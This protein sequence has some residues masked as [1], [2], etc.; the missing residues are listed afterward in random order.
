[1]AVPLDTKTLL[2][3]NKEFQARIDSRR[4]EIST[5]FH[6]HLARSAG[7][8]DQQP[9]PEPGTGTG[10]LV[11]CISDLSV[12]LHYFAAT[13]AVEQPIQLLLNSRQPL[14]QSRLI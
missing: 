10:V 6:H 7:E 9:G 13:P 5:S 8:L 1:M 2:V 11:A 12:Q 3:K 4:W 14:L